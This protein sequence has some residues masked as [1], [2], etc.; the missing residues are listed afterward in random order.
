MRLKVRTGGL[1][2]T[3]VDQARNGPGLSPGYLD[4][5]SSEGLNIVQNK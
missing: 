5:V 2:G 4:A 1:V 3:I